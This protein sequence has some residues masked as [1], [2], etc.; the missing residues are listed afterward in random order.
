MMNKREP[1]LIHSY[2]IYM[3]AGETDNKN[4][5]PSSCNFQKQPLHL[6]ENTLE[7]G[8]KGVVA[9]SQCGDDYY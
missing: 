7:K 4:L 1:G 2:G 3:V 5:D 9:L 6:T 8:D